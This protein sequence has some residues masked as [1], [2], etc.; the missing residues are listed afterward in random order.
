[1]SEFNIETWQL[2]RLEQ[3]CVE[4]LYSKTQTREFVLQDMESGLDEP[5]KVATDA[6]W[7]YFDKDYSY[8]S[9]NIRLNWFI[10]NHSIDMKKLVDEILVIILPIKGY[11]S[12]QTVVGK[13]AGYLDYPDPWDSIKTA[14]E[15]IAVVAKSD[16][17]SLI[18]ARNS[19]SGSIQVISNYTLEDK[20]ISLL[21][22]MMYLPPLLCKPPKI[23]KNYQSA[24]LTKDE[25]L[26][27]GKGNHHEDPLALDAINIANS[28]PLSLDL[29]I[30]KIEETSKKPLDTEDKKLSF[31]KM[32]D[33]SKTVYKDIVNSGNKFY[34]SWRPDKRGRIYSSGYHIN[35]QSS[36]YKKALINLADKEVIEI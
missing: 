14:A 23:T 32:R 11:I 1:M 2:E 19:E 10:E 27:L 18:P 33:Q 15:I 6:L 22:K 30:L 21:D 31:E 34:L 20:T 35:I 7:E 5:I 3:I 12:I 13:L 24:Y 36:E 17:Y 26:I 29:E 28:I 9:K 25:S 16:L 8:E 4:D